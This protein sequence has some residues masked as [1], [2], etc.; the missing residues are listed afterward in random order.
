MGWGTWLPRPSAHPPPPYPD[1]D[2][3]SSCQSTPHAF[4]CRTQA[5]LLSCWAIHSMLSRLDFCVDWC[6]AIA[7]WLTQALQLHQGQSPR[8]ACFSY[9]QEH[10]PR[11]KSAPLLD[12]LESRVLNWDGLKAQKIPRSVVPLAMFL[13]KYPQVLF[14]SHYFEGN[15]RAPNALN[16]Q[17]FSS[18]PYKTLHIT[19][20]LN[21]CG[22][23]IPTCTKYIVLSTFRFH[24]DEIVTEIT[25][26]W[27]ESPNYPESPNR[28]LNIDTGTSPLGL[29]TA[30]IE[31][32][33]RCGKM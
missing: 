24:A 2:P 32:L 12:T 31:V 19:P 27:E 21:S 11:F 33:L 25:H 15:T 26:S 10:L 3:P 23:S 5:R 6:R 20:A 13:L 14:P 7:L 30:R 22:N 18:Q 9:G 17:L 4:F 1:P 8:C 28:L 16:H 29:E